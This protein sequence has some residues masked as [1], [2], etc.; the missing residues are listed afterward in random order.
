M[1]RPVARSKSPRG[2]GSAGRPRR[3]RARRRTTGAC[4]SGCRRQRVVADADQQAADRVGSGYAN[5]A[6]RRAARRERR[7]PHARR[8]A[9]RRRARGSAPRSSAWPDG[10]RAARQH[11]ELREVAPRDEVVLAASRS[12]SPGASA[13]ARRIGRPSGATCHVLGSRAARRRRRAPCRS[14]LR[15]PASRCAHRPSAR[16]GVCGS[17]AMSDLHLGERIASCRSPAS[18]HAAVAAARSSIAAVTSTCGG[19]RARARHH[20]V[21]ARRDRLVAEPEWF[22]GV[23]CGRSCS[24]CSRVPKNSAWLGQT[25]AHIGFLPTDVRS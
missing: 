5:T 20:H 22:V 11:Q 17:S 2:T 9:R 13:A 25:V 8:R 14:A 3:A 16:I 19:A 1:L 15:A 7:D 23:D 18:T 6:R 24:I 4:T 12:G 21:D 10:E